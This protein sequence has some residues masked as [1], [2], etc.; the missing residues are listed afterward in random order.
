MSESIDPHE[1]LS[2]AFD[3]NTITKPQL[4]SILSQQGIHDLPPL[5]A[6]KEVLVNLFDT[7]IKSRAEEIK[8]AASKVKPSAYG[9]V[10][11]DKESRPSPSK[12]PTRKG[13][14]SKK[15]SPATEKKSVPPSLTKSAPR[16]RR[17]SASSKKLSKSTSRTRRKPE[18]PTAPLGL[19]QQALPRYADSPVSARVKLSERIKT[20]DTK[21]SPKKRLSTRDTKKVLFKTFKFMGDI[22]SFILFLSI[23]ISFSFYVRWKFLYPFPYC[24]NGVRRWSWY[25]ATKEGLFK[26]N[27]WMEILENNCL[28]CPT[29]ATCFDG[30]MTCHDGYVKSPYIFLLGSHC[31]P[32]KKKLKIIDQIGQFILKELVSRSG[33]ALCGGKDDEKYL[34]MDSE[35]EQLILKSIN[36][37]NKPLIRN[38][39]EDLIK[40]GASGSY[41]IE[42]NSNSDGGGIYWI[43]N[44]KIPIKCK[45]LNQVSVWWSFYRRFVLYTT[46]TSLLSIGL[47]LFIKWKLFFWRRTDEMTMIIYQMLAE[48]ASLHK[49]DCTIPAAIPIDQIKDAILMTE[50]YKSFLS[51]RLF[52]LIWPEVS[53]KVSKNSNVTE[54]ELHVRGEPM[55]QW[56][57]IGMDIF[58]KKLGQAQELKEVR[59]DEENDESSP[60]VHSSPLYKKAHYPKIF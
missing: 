15:A 59:G 50:K 8:S 6:K 5:S 33:R 52:F 17:S 32:D 20:I 60:F 19:L 22:L 44:P 40:G 46:I 51:R 9:I 16:G 25:P 18:S 42:V 26:L 34:K 57:W 35:F 37:S 30:R 53:S 47:F 11:L 58:S 36:T 7:R 4:R 31:I 14:P 12:S 24:D 1:Y 43:S 3:A 13:S 48:N 49:R 39:I 45:I 29:H 21:I 55:A 27:A 56:E 38:A 10:M 28:P 41:K 23:L 2:P 54:T